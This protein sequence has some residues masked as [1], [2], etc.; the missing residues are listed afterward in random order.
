MNNTEILEEC[1][2]WG[3]ISIL[4]AA[5]LLTD[6]TPWI[7]AL[8]FIGRRSSGQLAALSLVEL[9]IY[10]FLEIAWLA[11]G[12]TGSVLISQADGAGRKSA[13]HG[14][15]AILMI[16]MTI[17]SSLIVLVALST[18]TILSRMTPDKELVEFGS[19][20]AIWIIPAIYFAGFQELT[21]TYF[22]ATGHAAFSTMSSLFYTVLDVF[23][24]YLFIVGAFGIEP[25]E[26]GLIGVAMSWNVSSFLGLSLNLLF[27]YW[28]MQA[29]YDEAQQEQQQAQQKNQDQVEIT[30]VVPLI[31]P[32]KRSSFHHPPTEKGQEKEAGYY[33]LVA[34]HHEKRKRSFSSGGVADHG[35]ELIKMAHKD[36]L[37]KSSLQHQRRLSLDIVDEEKQ[38]PVK[39]GIAEEQD[40][41]EDEGIDFRETAI[42]KWVLSKTAWKRLTSMLIPMCIT[43]ATECLIFF[44]LGLLVIRLSRAQIAAHNTCT[45]IMEYAFSIGYA[46]AEATSVRIG[47]YVGKGDYQGSI[48]VVWISVFTSLMIGI[49]F[50]LVCQRYSREIALVFTSD[51][52]IIYY[53]VQLSPILYPTVAIFATGDQMLAILLGQGRSKIE[54]YLALFSL[55]GITFPLA[56]YLFFFVD[57]E[58]PEIWWSFCV[59]YIVL[60]VIA[61]YFVYYSDWE[62]LFV[63]AK[64]Y[65]TLD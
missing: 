51:P 16:V 28:M 24:N 19:Q 57:G 17:A 64:Q 42:M 5:R 31:E 54:M 35:Y 20:Y 56:Y 30:E 61:V 48:T 15:L 49:I 6:M 47:Y 23:F 4:S 11:I 26:N 58:L 37:E 63:R 40:N 32:K 60:E 1:W 12:Q 41:D 2:I 9:W 13:K 25:Y 33:Q 34:T 65:H 45:A 18:P 46:M 59:G 8:A 52:K 22:T 38:L 14:W 21:S 27:L 7:A 55:W 36:E 3:K 62:S 29:E 10:T 53:I 44:V 39:K 50:S 43:S